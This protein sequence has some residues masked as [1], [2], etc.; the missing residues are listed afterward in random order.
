MDNILI[1]IVDDD[2]EWCNELK[3]HLIEHTSFEILPPVHDGMEAIEVIKERRPDIILLDLILPGCE[4][5]D[6][7]EH[8]KDNMLSYRPII[9]LISAVSSGKTRMR[10]KGFENVVEYSIKPVRVERV[11]YNI[12]LFIDQAKGKSVDMTLDRDAYLPAPG[13]GH[14]KRD[15]SYSLDE[16][17]EEQLTELGIVNF[18]IS[19]KCIRAVIKEYMKAGSKSRISLK[20]VYEQVGQSFEPPLAQGSVERNV[21]HAIGKARDL[22]TPE[23]GKRFPHGSVTNS[24][25]INEVTNFLFRRLEGDAN[26]L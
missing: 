20:Q 23:F 15:S 5:R 17:M 1:L 7:V 6:I 22:R 13:G 3:A 25:F 8:I 18:G 10:L 19:G 21:R 2:T 9:Y 11:L 16:M 4:G 24:V 14:A 26:E 12:L